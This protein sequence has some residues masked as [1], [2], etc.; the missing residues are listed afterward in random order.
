MCGGGFIMGL[1]MVTDG[2]FRPF[3]AHQMP[4][5]RRLTVS[6]SPEHDA[7]L[8]SPS[9]RGIFVIVVFFFFSLLLSSFFFFFFPFETF[10]LFYIF[11]M[12]ARSIS[13]PYIYQQVEQKNDNGYREPVSQFKY[14]L[15]VS[16]SLG[17][18]E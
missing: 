5:A 16:K 12:N 6:L 17:E 4:S 10:S 7:I 13:F 9:L 18:T 3:L 2:G 1:R 11:D 15:P 14:L 8:P